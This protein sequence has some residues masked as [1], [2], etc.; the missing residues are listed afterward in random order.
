MREQVC[1]RDVAQL[2]G[3]ERA[4]RL[5]GDRRD[6]SPG[7][8]GSRAPSGVELAPE[9]IR[10][11]EAEVEQLAMGSRAP[12]VADRGPE[13][14]E[15]ALGDEACARVRHHRRESGLLEELEERGAA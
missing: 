7:E 2:A 4:D 9:G 13:R 3:V 12:R 1:L 6:H 5:D 10:E 8:A 11:P 15:E 14:V